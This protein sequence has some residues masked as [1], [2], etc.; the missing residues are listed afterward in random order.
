MTNSEMAAPVGAS[1]APRTARFASVFL[2]AWFIYLLV[3]PAWG[4]YWIDSWHNEQRAVQV[5]LL[6]ATGLVAALVPRFRHALVAPSVTTLCLWL[7]GLLGVVSALNAEFM[8][9]AFVEVALHFLLVLLVVVT[10]G[11]IR[12]SPA[13]LAVW[14]QR[15]CVVLALVHVGGIAARYAAMLSL[16]RAPDVEV[17]LLGFANPRFPSAL[18]ALLLPFVA[19]FAGDRH[20]HR[21]LRMTALVLLALLWCINL[22]LGTRAIWFA[23]ALA[24]PLVFMLAGWHRIRPLAVILAST[25]V[26]G[27]AVYYLLF[28]GVPAWMSL[29]SAM[30]SQT[31]HLTSLSDRIFLWTQSGR[32]MTEHLLL[33]IGPMNLAGL[34]DSYASH[35]HDWMLQFGTEWG[36]PVLAI[37]AWVLWRH[38]RAL[39]MQ[40]ASPGDSEDL[41]IAPLVA[42]VMALFYGMV[43]GNLVM[44]VS[45]SAFALVA[46][47]L[48]GTAFHPEP[49]V[50]A[51]FSRASFGAAALAVASASFMLFYLAETLPK[52]PES[53]DHWRRTSRHSNF[54]PRFWQ[55]GL[56]R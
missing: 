51:P 12:E 21:G 19:A 45:Q 7:V 18:Y 10:A 15:A 1:T 48:F 38:G 14:T 3:G 11:C 22:A 4:F 30:P 36:M 8:S 16:D 47:V 24:L 31:D 50:A 56:L 32:L 25:A 49:R 52:Q 17:L 40:R 37:L 53:E 23:Y 33:G 20:E 41:A 2:G 6:A 42:T 54:A 9:A 39:R 43:D 26:T 13:R 55:Q 34:G 28:I 29:G 27:V 35:P 5:I 44:P 46:G